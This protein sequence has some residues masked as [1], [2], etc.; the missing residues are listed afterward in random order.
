MEPCDDLLMAPYSFPPQLL[1]SGTH[2]SIGVSTGRAFC[3]LVGSTERREYTLMGDVVN[4]S[5]RLMGKCP[6]DGRA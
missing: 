1:G 6:L 2:A 3:G 5:A 4:L